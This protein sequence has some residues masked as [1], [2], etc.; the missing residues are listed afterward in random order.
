MG[1]KIGVGEVINAKI[2]E[3]PYTL[4]TN[5]KWVLAKLGVGCGIYLSGSS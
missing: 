4:Q 5:L 2:N 1:G 3:Q